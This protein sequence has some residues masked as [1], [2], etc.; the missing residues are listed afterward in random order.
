ME[1][2]KFDDSTV[3]L[4]SNHDESSKKRIFYLRDIKS[5]DVLSVYASVIIEE[6]S[7]VQSEVSISDDWI[8][9]RVNGKAYWLSNEDKGY[10]EWL[11]LPVFD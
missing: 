6:A 1:R 10:L 3:T 4:Y 5:F 7:D 11:G 2:S 9:V 8:K